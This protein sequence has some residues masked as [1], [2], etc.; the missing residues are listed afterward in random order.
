MPLP[1]SQQPPAVPHAVW[2]QTQAPPL[3]I[4]PVP[5]ATQA[6]PLVP[7]WLS[8]FAVTQAPLLVSQHPLSAP[9]AVASQAQP[10][11]PQTWPGLHWVPQVRQLFVS[12]GTQVLLQQMSPLVVQSVL[13][14]QVPVTHVP[15]QLT[16]PLGQTQVVPEQTP[17]VG[18]VT[19]AP[20]Q[21]KPPVQGVRSESV[22]QVKPEEHD[23]QVPQ[24]PQFSVPPQLS[25]G[26][27]H[28]PD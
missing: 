5:Q 6:A 24:S 16:D 19:Q 26:D 9:Q 15:P 27:P 12:L 14:Q 23:W 25:D 20:P 18:H 11:L 22:S 3:Q 7:H 1:V 17:P 10:P 13:T 4:C 21:Q 8:L 2:S 28:W